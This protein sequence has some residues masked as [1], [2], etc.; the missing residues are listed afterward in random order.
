MEKRRLSVFSL[1]NSLLASVMVICFVTAAHRTI[2]LFDDSWRTGLEPLQ[3][4]LAA[5]AFFIALE[6]QITRR[7]WDAVP[8]FGREWWGRIIPEAVLIL[9]GTLILAWSANGPA[10]TLRDIPALSRLTVGVLRRPEFV[11]SL[12]VAAAAWGLS[13]F[14]T[15][16]LMALETIP[17]AVTREAMRGVIQEQ[18]NARNRL[19]QDVFVLSGG[20]VFFSVFSLSLLNLARG[21]PAAFGTLGLETPVFLFC[22]FGLFVIGRLLILRAEWVTERTGINPSVT[23]FWLLYGSAFVL[24][25]LL[26]A[27]VL[28]T[29]YSFSLLESLTVVIA[30]LSTLMSILW[31]AFVYPVIWLLS[32]ILPPIGIPSPFEEAPPPVGES[33][34]ALPSLPMGVT[35]AAVAREI[36]FWGLAILIAAYVLRRV[37][38]LRH[39]FLRHLRRRSFFRRLLDLLDRLGRRLRIWRHSVAE[40]VRESWGALQEDWGGRSG[41]ERAGFRILRGLDPRQSVR[42]Y[43]FALLRR[44]AERGIARRPAQTPREYARV[45]SEEAEEIREELQELTL[46]FEEARYTT[47]PVGSERVRRVRRVWDTIRAFMR[48]PRRK[49]SSGGKRKE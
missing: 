40:A 23:R 21:F 46:A 1:G 14:L 29:A 8:L 30:G 45:L 47:H 38:P 33:D 2:G 37:L 9:L 6:V 4:G 36:L 16:D 35:W 25:V 39:A 41:R 12:L 48:S 11:E 49:N 34:A 24:C 43:F 3:G 10:I 13:R 26:L 5:G 17:T 19:W 42:F 15:I 20:M 18:N 28:P 22:G 7:L 31:L 32:R 27:V 44:G